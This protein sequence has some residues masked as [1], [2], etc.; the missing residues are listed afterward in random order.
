MQ[1]DSD[2]EEDDVDAMADAAY[3]HEQQLLAEAEGEELT[4]ASEAAAGAGASG[5]PNELTQ[6]AAAGG[7]AASAD[8]VEITGQRSF[9][10]RDAEARRRAVDLEEPARNVRPRLEEPLP[11][12]PDQAP[13]SSAEHH[14]GFVSPPRDEDSS[15]PLPLPDAEATLAAEQQRALDLA[16]GGSNLFLTGGPGTGK[17]FTL[18][19]II[20]ALEEQNGAG[21]VLVWAPTGVAAIL[22]GGQTMNSKPGPGVPENSDSFRNMWG[23][24]K[25]WRHVRTLVLDEVSMVDAEFLDWVEA[26]V[27]TMFNDTEFGFGGNR[28]DKAFGGIQLVFCGDFCQLPP[29]DS[30]KERLSQPAV[31]AH[32][33][34]A[35]LTDG[36]HDRERS[37]LP[38]G[39]KELKGKWCFQTAAWRDACF[40]AVQLVRSFRTGDQLLLAGLHELRRGLAS[41]PAV[42]ALVG[43]TQRALPP[44]GDGIQPTV[45]YARKREV[46][47]QNEDELAQLDRNTERTYHALDG[48]EPDHETLPPPDP[49]PNITPSEKRAFGEKCPAV[50]TL[51]LRLG[52]QVMLIK[53]EIVELDPEHD[54]PEARRA[55]AAMELQPCTGRG[56]PDLR[57]THVGVCRVQGARAA[58]RQRLARRRGRLPPPR[59]RG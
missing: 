23:S 45:L 27:R 17:S 8:E 47:R 57:L 16:L 34:N 24:K 1:N 40:E 15:D 49:N 30:S 7:D 32:Y 35:S 13:S 53:N 14:S 46:E 22:V 6:T 2:T 26:H 21:S 52:A 55:Y 51:K 36:G 43:A 25:Y 56:S 42:R 19:R 33:E 29:V 5:S 4:Q 10:E 11:T 50:E 3:E 41:H 39:L 38:V 48:V 54:T 58:A 44:R 59:A 9:A 20:A 12:P 18:R 37:V 28:G 31:L